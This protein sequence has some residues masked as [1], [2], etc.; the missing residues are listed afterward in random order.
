MRTAPGP[1]G[2]LGQAISRGL[3]T[4]EQALAGR[5][6]IADVS[7]S[8]LV[9]RVELDAAPVAFVKSRGAAAHLDG[10]D[11]VLVETAVLR[12]LAGSDVGPLVLD[13]PAGAP[14]GEGELWTA[15]V[16]GIPLYAVAVTPSG[17]A[18]VC[19]AWGETLAALHLWPTAGG[20]QAVPTIQRPW[21]LDPDR[22]PP[23]MGRPESQS[24]LA[25]LLAAA[26]SDWL[27]P[28]AAEVADQWTPSRWVHGDLAAANVLVAGPAESPNVGLVDF[29]TAGL[30]PAEWDLA[31]AL[32]TL[33][34]LV[35]QWGNGSVVE[36]FVRGYRA[37]G[38]PARVDTS[39]LAVRALVTGWQLTAGML[40]RGDLG[41][42]V[43]EA[44]IHLER[45]RHWA[46]HR[47]AV[48]AGAA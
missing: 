21:V 36:A 23:S 24:P 43:A 45:A 9:H 18:A 12:L 1:A 26:H 7:R 14:G 33:G 30:G 2:L 16:D 31:A 27:A 20:E 11:P 29:E 10:D 47:H 37:A 6:A 3:V 32:D 8:N 4:T 42:A 34:S 19:R 41:G 40:H 17:Q 5:V 48:E 22:L 39:H 28:A 15:P 38:G 46:A 13:S 25:T 44:R 35:R